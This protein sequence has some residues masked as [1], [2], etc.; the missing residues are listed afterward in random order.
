MWIK[1]AS[2]WKQVAYVDSPGFENGWESWSKRRGVWWKSSFLTDDKDGGIYVKVK[3]TTDPFSEYWS[4]VLPPPGNTQPPN[5]AGGARF[6]VTITRPARAIPLTISDVL[7]ELGGLGMTIGI[8]R[9]IRGGVVARFWFPP[10]TTVFQARAAIVAE[11]PAI[12]RV[13]LATV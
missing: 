5:L 10:A 8:F 2:G 4:L 9:I 6:D 7:T 1:R 13:Q 3:E 11:M 12:W